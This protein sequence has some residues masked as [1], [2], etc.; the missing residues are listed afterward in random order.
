[1]SFGININMQRAEYFLNNIYQN[2]RESIPKLEV[3]R[4][5]ENDLQTAIDFVSSGKLIEWVEYRLKL[6]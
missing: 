3:D 5:M 6:N 2:V 1:M 4:F